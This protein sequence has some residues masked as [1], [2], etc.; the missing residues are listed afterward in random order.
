[1]PKTECGFEGGVALAG[2]PKQRW[3]I[4]YEQNLAMEAMTGDQLAAAQEQVD[5]ELAKTADMPM[6]FLWG[7]VDFQF[8]E[9]DFE[10]WREGLGDSEGFTYIR[11]PGLNHLF[12]QAQRAIPSRTRRRFTLAADIAAWFEG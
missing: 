11:Y 2:T 1:M 3:E 7:E 12:M 6:L 9:A 8:S 5:A 4:S 10:A